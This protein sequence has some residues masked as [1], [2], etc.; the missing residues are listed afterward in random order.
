MIC[1]GVILSD[2]WDLSLLQDNL[3]IGNSAQE[4]VKREKWGSALLRYSGLATLA[5]SFELWLLVSVWMLF[6][7]GWCDV[8]ECLW[9][10]SR[11]GYQVQRYRLISRYIHKIWLEHVCDVSFYHVAQSRAQSNDECVTMEHSGKC[12]SMNYQCPFTWHPDLSIVRPWLPGVL[13][14]AFSSRFLLGVS[15]IDCPFDK[16][17]FELETWF[18]LLQNEG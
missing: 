8:S 7:R 4:E 12:R 6:R 11:Y 13:E 17:V 14:V 18:Y 2:R 10:C 5:L 15:A 9:V 16:F 3:W 1:H